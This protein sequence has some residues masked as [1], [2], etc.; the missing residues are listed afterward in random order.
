MRSGDSR[1]ANLQIERLRLSLRR[2][3]LSSS[4]F[5]RCVLL[6]LL[7]VSQQQRA[8]PVTFPPFPTKTAAMCHP[9]PGVF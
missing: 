5:S 3:V 7:T 8:L 6:L 4:R 1:Y 2:V 9:P